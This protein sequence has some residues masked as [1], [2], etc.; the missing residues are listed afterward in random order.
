[1]EGKSEA[2]TEGVRVSVVSK[3]L[4]QQSAPDND[5]FVFA[6]TVTLTNEGEREVKLQTRHW[7]ITDANDHVEEV[8]GEGVVGEQPSLQPRQS[9]RYT[10]GCV[11]RTPW[12]T[13]HGSY[14]M[15]RD[16]GHRFDARIDPFLLASAFF[17]TVG[18]PS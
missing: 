5:R 7:V 18:G 13:M 6:Y 14:Q 3:Y 1:V 16:D 11:L 2:V 15:V 4:A 12:G 8:R 17:D 10:S 9:F